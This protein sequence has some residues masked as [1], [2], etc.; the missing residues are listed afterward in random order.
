MTFLLGAIIGF[1][2]GFVVCALLTIGIC[3][4]INEGKGQ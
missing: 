4:M 1:A 2:A 3:L